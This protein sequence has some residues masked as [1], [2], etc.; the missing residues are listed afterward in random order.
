MKVKS[1]LKLGNMTFMILETIHPFE[2]MRISFIAKLFN[3]LL[4][5]NDH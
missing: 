1:K 3:L 4:G 5:R 2:N